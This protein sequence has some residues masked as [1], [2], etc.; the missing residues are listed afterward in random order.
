MYRIVGVIPD[1]QYNDL[2]GDTPPMAFAP[3]SQCPAQGPWTVMMVHSNV[4]SAVIMATVK[5]EIAKKHPEI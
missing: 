3:V 2:R 1:T 5:R 4:L